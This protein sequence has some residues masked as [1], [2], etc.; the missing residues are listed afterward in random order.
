MAGGVVETWVRAT[1]ALQTRPE[2]KPGVIYDRT[3][4]IAR[5]ARGTSFLNTSRSALRGQRAER[6][7]A[8]PRERLHVRIRG[9]AIAGGGLR[10]F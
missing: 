5:L 8:D 2:W 7:D 9:I 6:W 1:D 4:L 3:I 10:V